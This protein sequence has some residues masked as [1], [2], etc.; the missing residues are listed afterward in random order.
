[1]DRAAIAKTRAT[2][3]TE[4]YE[5]YQNYDYDQ[6]EAPLPETDYEP[7]YAHGEEEQTVNSA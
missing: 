1:M 4:V 5:D 6:T 2:T 7:Y 3:T